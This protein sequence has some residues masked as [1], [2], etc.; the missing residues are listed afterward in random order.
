MTE[1][2]MFFVLKK[3]GRLRL[4]IDAR[5]SNCHFADP[6]PVQLC[7]GDSLSRIE[8]EPGESLYVSVADLKDAFYQFQLPLCWQKY[9]GLRPILASTLG[10]THLHGKV[11]APG[12]M[13]YPR[14]AVIPVG[15]TWALWWCPTLHERIV[16]TAGCAE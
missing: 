1:V 11:L 3:D 7:T 13:I 2:E 14:L 5:K 8:L 9:F 6:N 4:V 15:W 16:A 12:T 10:V